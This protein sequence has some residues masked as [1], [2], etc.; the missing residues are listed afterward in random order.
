[1]E[2]KIDIREVATRAATQVFELLDYIHKTSVENTELEA[3]E[4]LEKNLVPIHPADRDFIESLTVDEYAQFMEDFYF[5]IDLL[6]EQANIP[7]D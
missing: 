6:C 4:A 2:F 7:T 5:Q 1:M 3:A